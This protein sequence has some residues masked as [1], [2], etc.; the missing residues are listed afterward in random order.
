MSLM[1]ADAIGWVMA[2]I[3]HGIGTE[4][5]ALSRMRVI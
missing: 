1:L 5:P 4:F 3:E 2:A